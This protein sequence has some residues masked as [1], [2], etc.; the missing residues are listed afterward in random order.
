MLETLLSVPGL[1]EQKLSWILESVAESSLDN[2]STG[3]VKQASAKLSQNNGRGFLDKLQKVLS[4]FIDDNESDDDDGDRGYRVGVDH[5][6]SQHNV[7]MNISPT[8]YTGTIISDARWIT[9]RLSLSSLEAQAKGKI[10]A[11]RFKHGRGIKRP[12]LELLQ[13]TTADDIGWG[14]IILWTAYYFLVVDRGTP[15][16]SDRHDGDESVCSI[17]RHYAGHRAMWF[18]PPN[19]MCQLCDHDI[20]VMDQY[21]S[22]LLSELNEEGEYSTEARDRIHILSQFKG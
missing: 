6:W 14:C 4:Q 20:G 1:D 9:S 12:N 7:E 18:M 3:F 8:T 22:K 13:K 2:P 5:V 19:L 11:K 16:N 15:G 21:L 10:L 17:M